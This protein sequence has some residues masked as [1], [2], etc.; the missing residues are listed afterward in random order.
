MPDLVPG[1]PLRDAQCQSKRDDRDKSG[2]DDEKI[3][4]YI[5]PMLGL[6]KA[7]SIDQLELI[8]TI[9]FGLFVVSAMG[10]VGGFIFEGRGFSAKANKFARRTSVASLVAQIVFTVF[11]FAIDNDISARQRAQLNQQNIELIALRKNALPRTINIEGFSNQLKQASPAK[12]EIQFVAACSDC[13]SLSSWISDAFEKARWPEVRQIPVAPADRDWVGAVTK[14]HA[15]RS[16]ITV[17]INSPDKITADP[18]TS[19]GAINRALV[20]QFGFNVLGY[21]ANIWGMVDVQLPP[22]LIRIV[23]APKA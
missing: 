8:K 20:G 6:F 9:A 13:E 10:G 16:G 17:I 12:V 14:L 3:Y 2:H 7:L 5:F 22:D 21:S 11:I 23:I 4:Y 19:L 18:K 15:Q 1:I